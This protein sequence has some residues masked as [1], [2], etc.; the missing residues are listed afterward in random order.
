MPWRRGPDHV[1]EAVSER[2]GPVRADL[3]ITRG[4]FRLLHR[5]FTQIERLM[6][7]NQLGVIITEIIEAARSTL[8]IDAT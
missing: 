1:A 2:A 5:L 7:I 8:V 3:R 6:K 4:N